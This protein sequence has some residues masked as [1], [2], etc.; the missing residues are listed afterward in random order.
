MGDDLRPGGVA[1]LA[2][3][4]RSGDLDAVM[5]QFDSSDLTGR[6]LIAMPGMG[7][8]RFDR[9]V[10]FLCA[11]S[12]DGAIGLIVNKP[13]PGASMSD[14]M[15]QLQI[16]PVPARLL[17]AVQFG[18]PVEKARGFVLHTPDWANDGSTLKVDAAFS[19]TGTLDVL[20]E[21]AADGGPSRAMLT[22]GYSGWGPGQLEAEIARNG[23]LTA[24]A[25]PRIVYDLP[26]AAKWE[27]A[28]AVLGIDPLF[29]SAEAGRA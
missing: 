23:W 4:G 26:N 6:F 22:L 15:Q 16:A 27:A 5:T 18:G 24:A 10:I 13:A 2:R 12:A 21:M 20:R 3:A 25:S 11:H 29:L 1:A 8:P 17:P 14:L 9:A 19:M 7:D 28:L